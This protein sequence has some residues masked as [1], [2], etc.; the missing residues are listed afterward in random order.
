MS[1]SG[2]SSLRGGSIA[3]RAP[4]DTNALTP[5]RPQATMTS[6]VTS[7]SIRF[8]FLS[9]RPVPCRKPW[10]LKV[11]SPLH[12]MVTH[13]GTI[14]RLRS[15]LKPSQIWFDDGASAGCSNQASTPFR[16]LVH[17]SVNHW[18]GAVE[19]AYS[20]RRDRVLPFGVASVALLTLEESS[21]CLGNVEMLG[22]QLRAAANLTS[23]H[24]RDSNHPSYPAPRTQG[25]LPARLRA[26]AKTGP[27]RARSSR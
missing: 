23:R 20:S 15:K 9:A 10:D 17:P 1:N 26:C 24:L 19:L 2:L 5:R 11:G 25:R 4:I 27:G 12:H 8:V 13:V 18:A 22:Q 7:L 14:A 21:S 6:E 16:G 3:E